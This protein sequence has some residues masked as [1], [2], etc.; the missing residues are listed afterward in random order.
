MS[1]E[2]GKNKELTVFEVMKKLSESDAF[3]ITTFK[4]QEEEENSVEVSMSTEGSEEEVAFIIAQILHKC[5]D[6]T[7]LIG[8]FIMEQIKADEENASSEIIID[9]RT[10]DKGDK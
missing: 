2:G 6:L 3:V 9:Q 7:P 5:H 4:H 1:K 10:E 8:R